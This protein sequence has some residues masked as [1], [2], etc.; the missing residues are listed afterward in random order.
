M[1]RNHQFYHDKSLLGLEREDK[2][3]NRRLRTVV[4][5]DPPVQRGWV[6]RW[7]LAKWAKRHPQR[8]LFEEILQEVQTEQ[9]MTIRPSAWAIRQRRKLHIT[10][11]GF[12]RISAARWNRLKWTSSHRAYFRPEYSHHAD[13]PLCHPLP[14]GD[15]PHVRTHGGAILDSLAS[16]ASAGTGIAAQRTFSTDRSEWITPALLSAR[17]KRPGLVGSLLGAK[18]HQK[19]R[20][21]TNGPHPSG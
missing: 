17:E 11:Q 18:G 9:R 6:R 4:T 5:I 20:Q 8:Q 1:L 14:A 12:Q 13:Q 15:L 3:L 10:G 7:R 21:K 2:A 19:G 16:P